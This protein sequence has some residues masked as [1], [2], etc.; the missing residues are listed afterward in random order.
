MTIE[1]LVGFILGAIL[2]CCIEYIV[3]TI[4]KRNVRK[5]NRKVVDEYYRNQGRGFN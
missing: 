3:R 5:R 2:V 1:N 4:V